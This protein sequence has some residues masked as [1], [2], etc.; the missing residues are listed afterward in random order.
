[1]GLKLNERWAPLP[2]RQQ[3]VEVPIELGLQV[4]G[5]SRGCPS[6]DGLILLEE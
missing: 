2:L 4:T 1:M 3:E 5:G 6:A